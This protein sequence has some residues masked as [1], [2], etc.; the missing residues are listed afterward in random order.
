[1]K[2][3]N[4]GLTGINLAKKYR[5]S[6]QSVSDILKLSGRERLIIRTLKKRAKQILIEDHPIK[7]QTT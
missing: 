7:L 3:D 4:P 1:M 5:I 6:E 2:H